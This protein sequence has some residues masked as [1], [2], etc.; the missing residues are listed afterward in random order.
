MSRNAFIAIFL[1]LLLHAGVAFSGYLMPE[2][3]AVAIEADETPTIALDLPP[4]PEPEEPELVDNVIS[5]AP[6]EVAELAPPMQNDLPSAAIDSPFIQQIQA[7]PPPGMNRPSAGIVIP[8]NTRPAVAAKPMA[9]LFDLA[10]LDKKPVPT[11]RAMPQYPIDLKRAGT[12]GEVHVRFIVDAQGNVR[13]P[14]IL[15]ST[16]P[17]F[18]EAVLVALSKWKFRP[19]EKGGAKVNTGNV[20]IVIPFS[21]KTER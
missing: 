8:T 1:S 13:E 10:A 12:E 11:F 2:E 4:P 18:D 19:G 15:R 5:D 16:N 6:S 21:L 14:V 9:N 17:G 7:P 3:D 20:Q